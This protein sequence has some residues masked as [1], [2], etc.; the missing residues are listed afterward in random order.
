MSS[1]AQSRDLL[2]IPPFLRAPSCPL[3]LSSWA[4]ALPITRLPNYSIT[5]FQGGCPYPPVSPNFTQAHPRSPKPGCWLAGVEGGGPG[6]FLLF[7]FPDY[8]I[9][10][11]PISLH[12]TQSPSPTQMIL[13][14]RTLKTSNPSQSL[15]IADRTDVFWSDGHPFARFW[16]RAGSKMGG[17]GLSFRGK[18][19]LGHGFWNSSGF[20]AQRSEVIVAMGKFTTG[21]RGPTPGGM[22]SSHPNV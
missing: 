4:F 3:W 1:R 13:S 6:A 12:L 9:T 17:R 18:A 15:E 19:D 2:F 21:S 14:L 10:Q 8:A 22:H 7:K 20:Q 5:N 11:L 16:R